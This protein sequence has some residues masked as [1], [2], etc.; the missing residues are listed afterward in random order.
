MIPT[1]K[2]RWA[3]ELT[4]FA[5]FKNA[6]GQP[7]ARPLLALLSFD[8][9]AA[10][11]AWRHSTDM[12]AILTGWLTKYTHRKPV[13]IA[14]YVGII[15]AFCQFRRR[16]D[17]DAFIP[18]RSWAPQ[19]ATSNFLPHVFSDREIRLIIAETSRI[20]GSSR[21]RR[22]YRLLVTVLYCTGLRIGEALRI[23]RKDLNLRKACFRV[24]PS[25]GRIR[26]VPFHRDLAS[27]VRCW[28][29]EDCSAFTH[30]DAFVFADK[31]GRPWQIKNV[32]HNLRMLLRRCGLKPAA[33]RVGPRLHDLRHTMAVHRL[34]RWY[35]ER[36]DLHRMLPW[37]SAYLGHRNLLG[38]ERYLHAT[39]ELLAIAG[40]RLQRQLR[41]APAPA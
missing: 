14:T 41:L 7:Y 3:A 11:L 31:D 34:R 6:L 30:P 21:T 2:S 29:T 15:R 17:P 36:R 38:T 1:F 22:C 5:R 9:F 23:R 26:W 33:G 19:S 10:S 27:K 16:Y 24:G 4:A 28:L 20:H 8:R 32:S 12:A 18:D 40:R 39:P 13:T 35:R 37:L 25:K